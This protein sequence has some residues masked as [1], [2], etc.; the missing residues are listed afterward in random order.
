MTNAPAGIPLS[1]NWA[2]LKPLIGA[3]KK[4]DAFIKGSTPKEAAE[5]MRPEP[6][7]SSTE[8]SKCVAVDCEMVGVGPH[9]IRS[10][11]ARLGTLKF[12][13]HRLNRLLM[14]PRWIVFSALRENSEGMSKQVSQQP[15]TFVVKL[16]FCASKSILKIQGQN[17]SDEAHFHCYF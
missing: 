3:G 13:L 16:Y 17:I 5:A 7:G 15:Q 6:R 12:L 8:A 11:L 2:S 9:G 10:S 4:L 14:S 1:S